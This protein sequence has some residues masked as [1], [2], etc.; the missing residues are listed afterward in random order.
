MLVYIKL[1]V[2]IMNSMIS[3]YENKTRDKNVLYERVSSAHGSSLLNDNNRIINILH[4][5]K[6]IPMI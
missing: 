2:Q 3:C 5:F 6:S 1:C 4:L